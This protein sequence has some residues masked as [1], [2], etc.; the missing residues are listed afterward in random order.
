MRR[1]SVTLVSFINWSLSS[2]GVRGPWWRST[3]QVDMFPRLVQ[4]Y[5]DTG[6]IFTSVWDLFIFQRCQATTKIKNHLRSER[7]TMRWPRSGLLLDLK[8]IFFFF[9]YILFECPKNACPLTT[10]AGDPWY[11]LIF[12]QML[13]DVSLVVSRCRLL[14][15]ELRLLKM[16]GA[17]KL[18]ILDLTCLDTQ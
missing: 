5:G 13:H 9:Y 16:W 2:S 8:K 18:D 4:R 10:I 15:E 11:K 7:R 1:P 14:G 3:R 17:T 12:L 6:R